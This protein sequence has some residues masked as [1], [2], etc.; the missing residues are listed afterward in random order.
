MLKSAETIDAMRRLIF[1][2]PLGINGVMGTSAL[3]G[4]VCYVA[5]LIYFARK[6][7]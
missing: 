4:L 2:R 3:F 5:T 1:G 6:D 7:Y